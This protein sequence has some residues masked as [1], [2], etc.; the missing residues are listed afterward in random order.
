LFETMK[1]HLVE[2]F[3]TDDEFKPMFWT[4]YRV[5]IKPSMLLISVTFQDSG[6][7]LLE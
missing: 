5:S 7:I 4:G 3:L 6:K 2:K 1:V